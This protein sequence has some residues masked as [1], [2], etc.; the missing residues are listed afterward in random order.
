[1]IY[2]FVKGNV[3]LA[4]VIL[5]I[6]CWLMLLSIN[7]QMQKELNSKTIILGMDKVSNSI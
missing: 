1:M 2:L 4:I 7:K 6:E 3:I 5:F